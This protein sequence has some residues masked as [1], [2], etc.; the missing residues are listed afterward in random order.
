MTKTSTN[1]KAPKGYTYGFVQLSRA[2]YAD[3]W[4]VT[5]D[6]VE[7][8]A[9][10]LYAKDGSCRWEFY[11]RWHDLGGQA[12]PR[13]EVFADAWQA[14]AEAPELFATLAERAKLSQSE[15]CEMLQSL[16]FADKTET[17]KAA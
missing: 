2:W 9:I 7:E 3:S 5:V 8:I 17:Q 6:A 12:V 1:K 4:L 15:C 10:G 16:G 13:V 14:F 11:I